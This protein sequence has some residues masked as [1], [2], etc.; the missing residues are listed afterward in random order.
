M[1]NKK[2]GMLLQRLR[3]EKNLTQL[4]L[5]KELNVTHQSVSKWEKGD[6]IP[7]ISILSSLASFYH[8]TVDELIKGELNQNEEK[9]NDDLQKDKFWLIL[10]LICSLMLFISLF[11]NYVNVKFT[12]EDINP[13]PNWNPFNMNQIEQTVGVRGIN[14]FFKASSINLISIG[15][16]IIFLSLLSFITLFS[17]EGFSIYLKQKKYQYIHQYYYINIKKISQITVVIGFLLI[18]LGVLFYA[19]I[20][21][22]IGYFIGLIFTLGL[23]I[24]NYLEYKSF[25]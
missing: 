16:W 7:D 5:A 8:I 6:S 22:N 2:I 11:I 17:L 19:E 12:Y 25:I 21:F 18:L 9:V 14:L 24:I 15:A 20:S 3:K 4:E 23:Y 13:F 10:R 1:D